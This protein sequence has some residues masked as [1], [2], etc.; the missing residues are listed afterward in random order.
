M[1]RVTQLIGKIDDDEAALKVGGY[2]PVTKRAGGNDF[3]RWPM[4]SSIE[5]AAW[6]N[7]SAPKVSWKRD[8][9]PA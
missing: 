5:C 6:A 2:K 1:C 7:T 8:I 9:T 4:Y 3:H